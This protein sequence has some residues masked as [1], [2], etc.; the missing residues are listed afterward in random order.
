MHMILSRDMEIYNSAGD[1]VFDEGKYY[2][3][4]SALVSETERFIKTDYIPANV[5]SELIPY[6]IISGS[7][8]PDRIK[9]TEEFKIC[10]EFF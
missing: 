7:D 9:D 3:A 2:A 10:M 5:V 1:L 8:V 6:M 4:I